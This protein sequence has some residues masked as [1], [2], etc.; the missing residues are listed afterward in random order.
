MLFH[1]VSQT[2]ALGEPLSWLK[3]AL[4]WSLSKDIQEHILH[5]FSLELRSWDSNGPE[6]HS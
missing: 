3:I 2:I 4:F 5:R 6:T 1:H